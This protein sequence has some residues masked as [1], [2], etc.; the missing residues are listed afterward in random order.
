M[1]G[2]AG[3]PS[4][5]GCKRRKGARKDGGAGR[6]VRE[7]KAKRVFR[8]VRR[9]NGGVAVGPVMRGRA[10]EASEKPYAT[11]VDGALALLLSMHCLRRGE[12]R[13]G[14]RRHSSH[15]RLE[16]AGR[17]ERGWAMPPFSAPDRRLF[18]FLRSVEGFCYLRDACLGARLVPTYVF[19]FFFSYSVCCGFV[20]N[21][22]SSGASNFSCFNPQMVAL[23]RR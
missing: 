15:P 5:G 10:R 6:A 8:I 7:E 4:E 14:G 17:A 12:R 18:F 9:E 3:R 20:V 19:F 23:V 13:G 22:F 21:L 2:T 11:G 16:R 1:G